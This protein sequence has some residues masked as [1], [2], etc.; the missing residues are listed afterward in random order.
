MTYKQITREPSKN[1]SSGS[2]R[3]RLTWAFGQMGRVMSGRVPEVAAVGGEYVGRTFFF[4]RWR[5]CDVGDRRVQWHDWIPIGYISPSMK[6][7][8]S[9]WST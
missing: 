3:E 2:F 4:V 9:V 1:D 5:H 7:H 6:Y 8:G